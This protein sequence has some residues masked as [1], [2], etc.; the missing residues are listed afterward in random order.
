VIGTVSAMERRP[1]PKD[2]TGLPGLRAARR[3][4]GLTQEQLAAL[5]GVANSTICHLEQGV[6]DSHFGTAR[7]LA[8][9]LDVT[10][11]QLLL[12]DDYPAPAL[13]PPAESPATPTPMPKKQRRRG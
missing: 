9:A 12:G 3:A 2:T 4:K 11:A 13:R 5:T 1:G 6:R 7:R 8:A 10:A